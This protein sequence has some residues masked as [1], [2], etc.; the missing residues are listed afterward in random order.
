[1]TANSDCVDAHLD[2]RII[3]ATWLSHIA[4]VKNVLLSNF[5]LFHEMGHAEDFIHAWGNSVNGG[6]ATNFVIIS[7]R[8]FFGALDDSGAFFVVRVPSVFGFGASFLAKSR[9]G[10]LAEAVFDNFVAGGK[11]VGF[12][13]T[14]FF[15]GSFDGVGDFFDL[16]VGKRV[17]VDLLPGFL[18][19]VETIILSALSNKK[20][21]MTELFWSS[22][23]KLVD[24]LENKLVIF[25][26][27]NWANFE[28]VET[29]SE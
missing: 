1:M 16:L 21:Q 8:E 18:L 13:I 4:K 12:P 10:D 9:E 11:L 14:K 26:A 22:I 15:G 24:D 25:L 6:S 19:G 17:A 5:E 3:V 27:G 20:M 2:D 23:F 29:A 28:M 7:R